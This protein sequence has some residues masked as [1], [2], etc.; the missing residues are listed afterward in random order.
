MD[1]DHAAEGLAKVL[2][3]VVLKPNKTGGYEDR[4]RIV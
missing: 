3:D 2:L 4:G 1:D